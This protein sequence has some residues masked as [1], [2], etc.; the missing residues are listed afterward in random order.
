MHYRTFANIL[1]VIF[2]WGQQNSQIELEIAELSCLF[3]WGYHL[4]KKVGIE[5]CW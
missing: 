1:W 4:E 2:K 3:R 5:Y